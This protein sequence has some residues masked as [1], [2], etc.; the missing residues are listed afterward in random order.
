MARIS[1]TRGVA[2]RVKDELPLANFII[3]ELCQYFV[4][5]FDV[6][7]VSKYIVTLQRVEHEKGV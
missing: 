6:E 5:S 7:S 2:Y 1:I 3:S 4:V